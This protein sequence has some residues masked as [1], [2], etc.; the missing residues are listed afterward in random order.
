MHG[1]LKKSGHT[2]CFAFAV[3]L[4]G[5]A[6]PVPSAAAPRGAQAP[7]LVLTGQ[8]VGVRVWDLA[9]G[10]EVLRLQGHARVCRGDGL[11]RVVLDVHDASLGRWGASE[12]APGATGPLPS[13]RLAAGAYSPD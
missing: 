3:L 1:F 2:A 13:L 6:A 11:F 4:T 10:K 12:R 7:G 9:A 5:V 8:G